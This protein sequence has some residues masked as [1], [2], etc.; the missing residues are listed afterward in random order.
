MTFAFDIGRTLDRYPKQLWTI[1]ECLRLGGHRAVVLSAIG[2]TPNGA[3]KEARGILQSTGFDFSKF[4]V[5]T[6]V[7]DFT[8]AN[9]SEWCRNNDCCLLIDDADYNMSGL[10]IWSPETARIQVQ[11]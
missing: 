3:I 2:T 11:P 9:K 8:G 10:R 4:E 6:V 5:V 7:E 1:M